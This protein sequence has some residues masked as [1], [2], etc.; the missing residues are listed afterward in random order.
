MYEYQI[1]VVRPVSPVGK[2]NKALLQLLVN[3]H[4]TYDLSV[5]EIQRY[6]MFYCYAPYKENTNLVVRL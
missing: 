1:P 4:Q 5:T 3:H 6:L 2:V